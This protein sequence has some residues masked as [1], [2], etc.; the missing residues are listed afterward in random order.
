M[1]SDT[2]LYFYLT[3]KE[4]YLSDFCEASVDADQLRMPTS[5]DFEHSMPC[6]V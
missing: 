1:C 4:I 6:K 5:S 2:S 3:G